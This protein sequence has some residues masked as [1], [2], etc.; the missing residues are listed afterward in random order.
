VAQTSEPLSWR[1]FLVP[2]LAF[3]IGAVVDL[4]DGRVG[5][6][7]RVVVILLAAALV[8]LTVRQRLACQRYDG[9]R[10]Q[11]PRGLR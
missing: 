5:T 2:A 1:V 4:F 7:Q 11:E 3:C 10:Y 6:G 8:A 9:P